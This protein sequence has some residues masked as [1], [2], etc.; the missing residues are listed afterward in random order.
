MSKIYIL[1]LMFLWGSTAQATNWIDE[2]KDRIKRLNKDAFVYEKYELPSQA[3]GSEYHNIDFGTLLIPVPVK[4]WGNGKLSIIEKHGELSILLREKGGLELFARKTD[5]EEFE[6]YPAILADIDGNSQYLFL[7]TSEADLIFSSLTLDLDSIVCDQDKIV[8]MERLLYIFNF[9]KPTKTE[10]FSSALK[11]EIFVPTEQSG[12]YATLTEFDDHYAAS[13]WHYSKEL[14]AKKSVYEVIY[15]WPKKLKY[16]EVISRLVV[17][18][19]AIN[20]DVLH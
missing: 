8:E 18:K 20:G 19:S 3:E 13:F 16:A 17:I 11:R 1:L 5:A 6:Y 15:T 7:N 14:G 2:C 9:L 12:T 10:Q 4:V